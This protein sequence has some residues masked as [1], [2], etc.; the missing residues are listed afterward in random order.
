MT[1]DSTL[2]KKSG[3]SARTNEAR[4]IGGEAPLRVGSQVGAQDTGLKSPFSFDEIAAFVDNYNQVRVASEYQKARLAAMEQIEG[5]RRNAV[6]N[7]DFNSIMVDSK[8]VLEERI[9]NLN[10]G[11]KETL[12]VR[13][14]KA[15]DLEKLRQDTQTFIVNSTTF[16][17][18]LEV[19]ESLRAAQQEAMAKPGNIPDILEK[20]EGFRNGLAGLMR[21][22]YVKTDEVIMEAKNRAAAIAV[23]TQGKIDIGTAEGLLQTVEKSLDPSVV[24]NIRQELEKLQTTIQKV[25]EIE[26][27]KEQRIEFLK[28]QMDTEGAMINF[29]DNNNKKA[30][31]DLYNEAM[32]NNEKFQSRFH[33]NKDTSPDANEDASIMIE[34]LIIDTGILPQGYLNAVT[35]AIVHSENPETVVTAANSLLWV[36]NESPAVQRQL[37]NEIS[38]LDKANIISAAAKTSIDPEMKDLTQIIKG[39]RLPLEEQKILLNQLELSGPN[40]SKL[41]SM[42][43]FAQEATTPELLT[44]P[45]ILDLQRVKSIEDIP[46]SIIHGNRSVSKN[47]ITYVTP[48]A[49]NFWNYTAQGALLGG[50]TL[51]QAKSKA[52][53][54][55]N[56]FY[57]ITNFGNDLMEGVQIEKLPVEKVL[58]TTTLDIDDRLR[59]VVTKDLATQLP[60]Y[61]KIKLVPIDET[62]S[63]YVYF[64]EDPHGVLSQLQD[65]K[66]NLF[67]FSPQEIEPKKYEVPKELLRSDNI[68]EIDELLDEDTEEEDMQGINEPL[69]RETVSEDEQ[70]LEGLIN[71][72]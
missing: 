20:I 34:H 45:Q 37:S 49:V 13:E 54:A 61:N 57:G 51:L 64:E 50:N 21:G 35:S 36:Y 59:R 19:K 48:D 70:L 10:F 3:G 69:D 31:E 46:L 18:L 5:I 25:K 6:E 2:F 17:G 71:D 16:R 9:D 11:I 23:A 12:Q 4:F 1:I 15:Q 68:E 27:E 56:H 14:W 32:T 39:T 42:Q 55:V 58:N 62:G 67:V 22:D 47:S 44:T 65:K 29:N 8:A 24:V 26:Q 63:Y 40:K 72:N 38:L 33:V 52:N 30:M 53:T 43:D 41:T 28:A 60:S 7:G 66:G